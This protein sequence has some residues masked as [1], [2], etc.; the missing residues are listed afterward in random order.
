MMSYGVKKHMTMYQLGKLIAWQA[1][2]VSIPYA[3]CGVTVSTFHVP[4]ENYPLTHEDQG[5]GN[6]AGKAGL[7]HVTTLRYV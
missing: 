5:E 4:K 7:V 1:C 3:L 6:L 2:E